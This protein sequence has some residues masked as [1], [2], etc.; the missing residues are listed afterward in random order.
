MSTIVLDAIEWCDI[1]SSLTCE[2]GRRVLLIDSKVTTCRC[3]NGYHIELPKRAIVTHEEPQP[4]PDPA[5]T[6]RFRHPS[7]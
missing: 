6:P 1:G 2:C 7:K 4:L 3:G 5:L